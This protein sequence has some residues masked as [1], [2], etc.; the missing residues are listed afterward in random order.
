MSLYQDSSAIA[1]PNIINI[2]TLKTSKRIEPVFP[3]ARSISFNRNINMCFMLM[4]WQA[5]LSILY[6]LAYLIIKTLLEVAHCTNM[7]TETYYYIHFTGDKPES[8]RH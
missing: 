2:T 6:A 3:K 4:F 7:K 8:Y 5:Y 1:K